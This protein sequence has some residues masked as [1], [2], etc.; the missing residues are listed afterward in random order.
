[1][2]CA[3]DCCDGVTG[4]W[5]E[6]VVA[7]TAAKLFTWQLCKVVLA[8]PHYESEHIENGVYSMFNHQWH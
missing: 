1:M 5:H 3:G 2:A 7:H 6:Q 8:C 4:D